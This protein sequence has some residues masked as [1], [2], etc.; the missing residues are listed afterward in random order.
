ML[1]R[2]R[3]LSCTRFRG[4][5]AS[6]GAARPACALMWLIGRTWTHLNGM[7]APFAITTQRHLT[8]L[9][10]RCIGRRCCCICS[11]RQ[12][13]R[14]NAIVSVKGVVVRSFT[15]FLTTNTPCAYAPRQLVTGSV[16]STAYCASQHPTQ[17]QLTQSST[18]DSAACPFVRSRTTQLNFHTCFVSLLSRRAFS[19][20]H[21][22][23][24][25]D[26]CSDTNDE[27]RAEL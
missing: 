27:T 15:V 9:A 12:I 1:L 10:G 8:N 11:F 14:C 19:H 25:L 20:P 13:G 5:P 17:P 2:S 7:Q 21:S 4:I 3:S 6:A 22:I 16:L 26:K 23:S 24:K 18:R